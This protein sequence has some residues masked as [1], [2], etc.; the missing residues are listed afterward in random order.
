MSLRT[1]VFA[2]VYGLAMAAAPWSVQAAPPHH[3]GGGHHPGAGHPGGGYHQSAGHHPGV[4]GPHPGGGGYPYHHH[5]HHQQ[6][7]GIPG[8]NFNFS[9]G[10]Y[11]YSDPS[12]YGEYQTQ[13]TY[14]TF[15]QETYVQGVRYAVPAGYEGYPAG[16]VITYGAYNYQIIGDGTMVMVF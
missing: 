2:G 5:H 3:G 16:S 7:G 12:Y 6:P 13:P 14:S 9:V 1:F 8:G 4:G 11:D 15:S 10:V